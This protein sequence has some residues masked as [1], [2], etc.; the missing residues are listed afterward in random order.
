[1]AASERPDSFLHMIRR[2]QRGRLKVYLGYCAGVG[3][4]YQM[5]LEGH[6]LKKDG[7]D[8]VVG[9]VESHGRADTAKLAERMEAVR[10]LRREYRGVAL[11]EMDAAA[12][13]ARKPQVVLID[14]LAHINVPDGRNRKRYEDIQDIL[15]SGIHV[16]TTLNIEHLESLYDTIESAVG[17]KVR[18]RLPDNVLAEADQ[19]VNVDVTAQDLLRRLEQGKIYPGDRVEAALA[20]IFTH[21][22]LEQLR[23]ITLRELASQIDFRRRVPDEKNSSPTLEQVMVCLSSAGPNS[24]MLLRY[25]SRLAGR[26]NRSWY[27]LYV[28]RPSEDAT[29]MDA[30]TQRALAGTLTLAKELGAMVFT[31]KG[32]DVPAT[33]L[34][35]AREYRVGH[36]VVGTPA[37]L[38]AWGRLRARKT[39]VERLVEEAGGI[40]VVVLDTRRLGAE[41]ALGNESAMPAASAAMPTPSIPTLAQLLAPE[42]IVIWNEPVLKEE[43]LNALVNA[44]LTGEDPA[45]TSAAALKI[46]ERE[47]LGSTFFNEGVAF[48]HARLEAL[49]E[50]C[51]ALGLTR[52]G[53]ADV[54]TEQPIEI[55]FLILSPAHPPTA[56]LRMLALTSKAAQ[57]RH[58]LQRLQAAATPDAAMKTIE[59]WEDSL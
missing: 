55:V 8:V 25:A 27:A 30:E 32:E 34:R 17:M 15:E 36:I 19:I 45:Q 16:I 53:I 43:V 31:Y 40:T 28:Q 22:N 50:S 44:A 14:E 10:R 58:F 2:S 21:R 54:I 3:K 47:H 29:A 33:I 18:E 42:R 7:V 13:I 23:E 35:F 41:A 37:R 4:T 38:S 56:Q 49:S 20:G 39:I 1:M 59:M 11:E 52:R 51:L 48:P 26:L 12:V 24:D 46:M 6:R 9:F 57:N 5:L